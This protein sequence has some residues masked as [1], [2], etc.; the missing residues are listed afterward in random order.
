MTFT[1]NKTPE[2]RKATCPNC[3]GT[4]NCYIRSFYKRSHE[5]RNYSGAEYW[6]ILEC[7]GCEEVFF[8]RSELIPDEL[9]KNWEEEWGKRP[10][11]SF[12]A[13]YWPTAISRPSPK[14][15]PEVK[16]QDPILQSLLVELY[17]ALDEGLQTLA[18]IGARTV[19]D[20]CSELLGIEPSNGFDKKLDGLE[21]GGHISMD[22]RSALAVLTD[23]GSA[24]AHRGWR[25]DPKELE[26]LMTI[27]EQFLHRTF[28]LKPAATSIS[29]PPRP[30]SRNKV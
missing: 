24:A 25:P 1:S 27:L 2:P 8:E 23:A 29:I 21:T 28:V 11:G 13:E 18:A 6:F 22:E 17:R 19:V 4:R 16:Q 30:R 3:G 14:W 5:F 20:R 9:L 10:D 12:T 26:V 15:L 7:M